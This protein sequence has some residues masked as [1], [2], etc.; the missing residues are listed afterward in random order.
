MKKSSTIFFQVAILIIGIVVL[1]IMIK[2]PLIEGRAENLDLISTYTDPFIVYLYLASIAFFVA[3]YQMFKLFEY[4]RQ[5]KVFSPNFRKSLRA[6]KYCAIVL[7]ILIV[8]AGLYIRIFH[9]KGD[10]PVGFLFICTV[11]AFISIIIAIVVTVFEKTLQRTIG[12]K[13]QK[14]LIA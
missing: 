1:A 10:D 6:I 7:A 5:S 13:S 14:D 9:S 3:L 11:A 2:F 12:I 4:I 8:T